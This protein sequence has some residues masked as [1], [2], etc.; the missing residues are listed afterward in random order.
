MKWI[1]NEEQ[2]KCIIKEELGILQDVYNEA[3]RVYDLILQDLP[4][5]PKEKN[6]NGFIAQK[7]NVKSEIDGHVFNISYCYRNI[8]NKET[9]DDY[10]EENLVTGGSAYLGKYRVICNVN[11][12]G[13]SGTIVKNKAIEV[14]Q[15]ELEH[16]LQ[17]FRSQKTIPNNSFYAKMRND[18]ESSDANRQKIGRLIYGCLKSEQEGFINGLYSF[19]MV[20]DNT[21]PPYDY[22]NIK[23]SEAGKLYIEIVSIFDELKTDQQLQ[24]ILKEYKWSVKKVEKHI[25]NFIKRIGR[26]LIKVNKDKLEK[27]W[28]K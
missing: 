19:C 22:S 6:S 25:E 11:F 24:N 8:L 20:D 17:E 28:R 4:N 7:G 18:M 23:N 3:L 16:I 2:L 15:H 9:I 14:I 12:Y 5:R 26:V 21:T 1:V 10:G 13:I 27:G